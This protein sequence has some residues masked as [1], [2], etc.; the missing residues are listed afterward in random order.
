MTAKVAPVLVENKPAVVVDM[1]ERVT[2]MSD[3]ELNSLHAN[4]LRLAQEGT[5]RQ[6][7]S[8]ANLIPVIEGELAAR[9]AS[10]PATPARK[11]RAASRAADA[12]AATS[13]TTAPETEVV[14]SEPAAA[15]E[16][17]KFAVGSMVKLS[18]TLLGLPTDG[19]VYEIVR[20]LPV[21]RSD[22]QYRI[23]TKDG[24]VERIVIE[25]QLSA[26]T[27]DDA[28]NALLVGRPRI[29]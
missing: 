29:R 3:G 10:L 22:F 7:A 5:D 6:R 23:R 15:V 16:T 18:R 17:H 12:I 25:T 4:A 20:Q 28:A 14:V 24:R 26:A 2:G 13:T 9:E 1:R 19:L 21:E 27:A 11:R 8:A